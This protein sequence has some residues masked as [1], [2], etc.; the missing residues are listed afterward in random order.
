LRASIVVVTYNHRRHIE[1]CLNALV[2]TLS[3]DDEIVIVD[4][5]SA[6]GTADYIAATFPAVRL[7][8]RTDNPGFGA[9]CNDGARRSQ[10]EFL[11]FLN[12]DT[13]PRAGWLDA[14]VEALRSIPRVGL[15]T[16]K[17]L[18]HDQSGLI[19]CVGH[20]MHISG[21]AT[22]RGLGQPASRYSNV[23]EVAA[24][25]GACFGIARDVFF[26]LGGFDER[27]FLYYEDDDLSLRARLAGWRCLAVPGAIVLHDHVQAISPAKLRYLER[28]RLFSILKTYRWRT[29]VALLPVLVCA[30][31]MVWVLAIRSGPAHIRAKAQAWQDLVRWAPH[32]AKSRASV[33]RQR[34]RGDNDMLRLHG[35]RLPVGQVAQGG[36]A[37]AGEWLAAL[38]FAGVRRLA[39][40]LIA[41]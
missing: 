10:A 11:F 38:A 2:A 31:I 27:L 16:P 34:V 5:A 9:A 8:R 41:T 21:I 30:E 14:L 15:V 40:A 17:L 37:A 25:S 33:Q 6:D 19:D 4:N 36:A 23:E 3:A 20:D 13:E 7:V 22:C 24:V 32:L 28:N 35:A 29:I 26:E 39:L 12:P 1:L 18:L